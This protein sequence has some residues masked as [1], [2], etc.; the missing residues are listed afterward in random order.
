MDILNFKYLKLVLVILSIICLVII[1]SLCWTKQYESEQFYKYNG[2]GFLFITSLWYFIISVFITYISIIFIILTTKSFNI[3]MLI[4][5]VLFLIINLI[6]NFFLYY[7]TPSIF[8]QSNVKLLVIAILNLII[9][10][11]L[12]I[13]IFRNSYYPYLSYIF[14]ILIITIASLGINIRIKNELII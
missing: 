11:V 1:L 9:S 13:F 7:F 2:N 10:L 6:F 3:Y 14:V 12:G 4:A 8:D 5:L